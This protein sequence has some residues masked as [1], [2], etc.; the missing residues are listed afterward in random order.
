[1]VGGGLGMVGG[2][3]GMAGKGHD[4]GASTT[5]E[6]EFLQIKSQQNQP[7]RVLW[8]VQGILGPYTQLKP[9]PPGSLP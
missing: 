6:E 9:P 8:Y 4:L 5:G 3:L 2:S 7:A 1:M